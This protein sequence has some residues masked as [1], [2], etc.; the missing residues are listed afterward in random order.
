V[1]LLT[2]LVDALYV[3][4]AVPC[5]QLP[6]PPDLLTLDT[7]IL[8]GESRGFVTLVLFRQSGL[9]V[10]SWP[11]VRLGFP[12][13]NLRLPAR[14]ADRV[15]SIWLLRQLVPAWVVPLGRLVARQ[16][17]SPA[18][19]R[20]SGAAAGGDA[21]RWTVGSASDLVLTARPGHTIGA[22]TSLGDWQRQVAF[23]RERPRG[24]FR[25]GDELCRIEAAF[26]A[27]D[28]LPQRVEIES[29]DWLSAQLPAVPAEV[30]RRPHSSFLVES[31]RLALARSSVSRLPVS[32]PLPAPGIPA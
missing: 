32:E 12:Q 1:E 31:T 23:F 5:A 13:C 6:E 11:A 7:A 26:D 27:A 30:W 8:D 10:A 18:R 3:N 15:A 28:G 14:D 22:G 19:L 9:R 4:W 17:V 21:V 2:E 29:A 25:R 20:R 16:P 24:Y